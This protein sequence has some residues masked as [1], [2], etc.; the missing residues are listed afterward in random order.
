[1]ANR[2]PNPTTAGAF[3]ANSIWVLDIRLVTRP[4]LFIAAWTSAMSDSSAPSIHAAQVRHYVRRCTGI[5]AL[6]VAEFAA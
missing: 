4:S 2:V 3:K 5:F 6:G 1:V